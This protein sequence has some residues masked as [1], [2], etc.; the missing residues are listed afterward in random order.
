MAELADAL[1]LGSSI[2]GCVGST[3]SPG[4]FFV[5]SLPLAPLGQTLHYPLSKRAYN[6]LV[7]FVALFCL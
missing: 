1:D 3:P 2:F 7:F 6:S 5:Y 4:T